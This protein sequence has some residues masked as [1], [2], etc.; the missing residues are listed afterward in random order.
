LNIDE[1]LLHIRGFVRVKL[2]NA[3]Y[4]NMCLAAR[5]HT[6]RAADVC[7]V[8]TQNNGLMTMATQC[9]I[10]LFVFDKPANCRTPNMI[11]QADKFESSLRGN[12]IELDYRTALLGVRIDLGSLQNCKDPLPLWRQMSV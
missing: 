12:L 9:E 4:V 3:E 1:E 8:I 7:L 6:A 11:R 10:G 2:H 5:I